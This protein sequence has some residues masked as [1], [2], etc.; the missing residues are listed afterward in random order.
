MCSMVLQTV[1]KKDG[2]EHVRRDVSV[3]TSL[4]HPDVSKTWELYQ[5]LLYVDS[6]QRSPHYHGYLDWVRAV[7]ACFTECKY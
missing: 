5:N 3:R 4:F 2:L 6:Y 7:C 1:Q